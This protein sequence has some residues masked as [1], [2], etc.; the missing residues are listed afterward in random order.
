[1]TGLERS[2]R[3]GADGMGTDWSGSDGIGAERP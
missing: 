1:V 3:N 2:G